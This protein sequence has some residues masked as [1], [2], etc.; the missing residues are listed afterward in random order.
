MTVLFLIVDE[1]FSVVGLTNDAFRVFEAKFHWLC[2]SLDKREGRV[3]RSFFV[4]T[5]LD[6]LLYLPKISVPNLTGCALKKNSLVKIDEVRSLLFGRLQ[7][8]HCKISYTLNSNAFSS[9]TC[10]YTRVCSLR[11]LRNKPNG[12]LA[13]DQVQKARRCNWL[14]VAKTTALQVHN[15]TCRCARVTFLVNGHT[16]GVN[17]SKVASRE[18]EWLL[19]GALTRAAEPAIVENER[20]AWQRACISTRR[21]MAWHGWHFH[22]MMLL[23]LMCYRV[24]LR[25][26]TTTSCHLLFLRY[27]GAFRVFSFAKKFSDIQFA[28]CMIF[29]Y[30]VTLFCL[31][32][33]FIDTYLFFFTSYAPPHVVVK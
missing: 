21:G 19:K 17:G 1:R 24:V 33:H 32:L 14:A 11:G 5:T 7:Y 9:Q 29:K 26:L 25:I 8:P 28:P 31:I 16:I 23:Y 13:L 10:A 12:Q 6:I 30:Y 3:K 27:K 15:A 20:T 22:L 4:T 18:L 2:S